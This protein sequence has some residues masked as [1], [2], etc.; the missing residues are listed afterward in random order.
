M[1][2]IFLQDCIHFMCSSKKNEI[3]SPIVEV[4][5]VTGK[6][7]IGFEK[8]LEYK[9]TNGVSLD[10]EINNEADL[11][12]KLERS[13]SAPPCRRKRRFTENPRSVICWNGNETCEPDSDMKIVFS[14]KDLLKIIE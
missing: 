9:T 14:E 5:T 11:E 7:N 2:K 8:P 10:F 1:Y 3:N 4:Y 12:F 6:I 13:S